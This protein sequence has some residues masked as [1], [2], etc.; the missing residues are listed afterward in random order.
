MEL[1]EDKM[2]KAI[3][4]ALAVDE[5]IDITTIG[6]RSGKP[7]RIEIWFHFLNETIYLASRPAKRSWNANL[8]ANPD[9]TFHFKQ[10]LQRDVAAM[11]RPITNP[12]TKRTVFAQM[13]EGELRM[14]HIDLEAWVAGSPLIQVEFT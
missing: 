2:D 9:F 1:T 14:A 12:A 10:S 6:R 11:A 8:L 5:L 3:R 4:N 7:R 13:R